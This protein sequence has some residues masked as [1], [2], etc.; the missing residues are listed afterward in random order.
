M[1]INSLDALETQL[2]RLAARWRGTDNPDDA[3]KIVNEY[4]EILRDMI[5]K[6]FNQSLDVDAE[7]PDKFLPVEYLNLFK[8][9]R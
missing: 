4:V 3:M 6:G 2:G 7:L 9:K 5:S 8:N 1:K